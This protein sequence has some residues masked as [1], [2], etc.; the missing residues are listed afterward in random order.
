MLRINF[1]LLEESILVEHATFLVIKETRALANLVKLF[2][3]Y[4]EESEL[5]LYDKEY[6]S[7]SGSALLLVSD[8][9]GHDINS[10]SILKLIY[11]DLEEQL[12]GKPEIKSEI[13]ILSLKI[14]EIMAHEI[15]DH[16]LDLEQDEITILELFK[17]LGIQIETRSDTIF[18]KTIEILQV[19]KFLSK[20]KILVFFNV[21]LY[22]T[23]EEII[24]ISEFISM[25]YKP[26]LF[27]ES[28]EIAGVKQFVLDE[29][30][31]LMSV[32]M[33]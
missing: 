12:N 33:V 3:Q 10:P 15:L 6:K 5:K 11:A 2:Y 22:L 1:P 9:L 19:Y 14:T 30:Y 21:S 13:E 32:D 29:D 18:E 31:F 23:K 8:V 27:I 16:E 17:I 7:L 28:R 26:V 4:D 20:K 25:L 24:E